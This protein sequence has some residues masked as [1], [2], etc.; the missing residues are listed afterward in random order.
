MVQ[1]VPRHSWVG[2]MKASAAW[3][4]TGLDGDDV[5]CPAALASW[6]V[7]GSKCRTS[8]EDAMT[9][10]AAHHPSRT[11]HLT[12]T[13]TSTSTSTSNNHSS[14]QPSIANCSISTLLLH[15]VATGH[16]T[17]QSSINM[18]KTSRGFMTPR[19]FKTPEEIVRDPQLQ[20]CF[21]VQTMV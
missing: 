16:R 2:T 10:V 8:L 20:P 7:Q 14:R 21:P 12:T 3:I 13:T 1:Q 11:S 9:R 6:Q 15:H 4:G 18:H 19:G 5:L 17:S